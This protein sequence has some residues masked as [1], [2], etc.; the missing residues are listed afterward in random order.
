LHH[1]LVVGAGD[2]DQRDLLA[3]GDHSREVLVEK[4]RLVGDRRDFVVL[5]PYF[6]RPHRVAMDGIAA[7]GDVRVWTVKL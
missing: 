1:K 6:L 5:C 2:H 7:G 3:Q 4:E